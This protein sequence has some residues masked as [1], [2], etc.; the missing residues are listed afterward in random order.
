MTTDRVERGRA[1]LAWYARNY[2]YVVPSLFDAENVEDIESFLGD[3]VADLMHYAAAL[4]LDF[5]FLSMADRHFVA[6]HFG[7]E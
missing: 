4:D 5:S 7:G 1:A 6:E 3:L 2:E